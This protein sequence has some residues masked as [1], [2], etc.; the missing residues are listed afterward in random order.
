MNAADYNA[1][2]ERIA[3]ELS[4]KRARVL[5][6]VCCAPCATA[7]LE[8]L[9]EFFDVTPFYYNPNISPREE[10]Q[11]RAEEMK[12]LRPRSEIRAYDPLPF[13]EISA[14][15][16]DAPEGGARCA[17]CFELRLRETAER[18]REGEYDYFCTTLSISPHKNA[19]LLN[20][21]GARVGREAGARWLPS[22]FKKKGGYARSVALS[23]ELSLYRQDYCGCAFSKA[24]REKRKKEF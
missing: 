24:E 12:R 6:H 5:L 2:T 9:E 8:R 7:C 4:G 21:I 16:E 1:Q 10:Y 17:K 19:A 13:A 23:K 22:D 3:A 18:A 11:R 20:E 14:G 15:L